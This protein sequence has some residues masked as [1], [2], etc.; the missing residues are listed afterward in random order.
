MEPTDDYSDAPKVKGND[1]QTF[2]FKEFDEIMTEAMRKLPGDKVKIYPKTLPKDV[3]PD[4]VAD[5]LYKVGKQHRKNFIDKE[6]K[7]RERG[8]YSGLVWA[9]SIFLQREDN[10]IDSIDY[11]TVHFGFG[12]KPIGTTWERIDVKTR[13]GIPID[14]PKN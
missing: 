6:K 11:P 8:K 1:F 12:D 3:T 14:K 5:K 7:E 13:K 10:I 4:Q 9:P 2:D